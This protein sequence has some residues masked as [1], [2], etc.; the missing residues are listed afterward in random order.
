[1]TQLTTETQKR[2]LPSHA[3]TIA[4]TNAASAEYM[5]CVAER[6]DGNVMMASV[7]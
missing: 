5:F 7:T 4:A 3:R 2:L 1:M 6:I